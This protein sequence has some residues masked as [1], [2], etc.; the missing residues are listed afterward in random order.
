M[1][2][3]TP[4]LLASLLFLTAHSKEPTPSN[5]TP[6]PK[7]VTTAAN[8]TETVKER[9]SPKPTQQQPSVSSADNSLKSRNYSYGYWVNGFRKN[10][11]DDSPDQLA[12]ETGYY[13]LV[14]DLD[15]LPEARFGRVQGKDYAS[16]LTFEPQDTESLAPAEL[17]I[18][19]ASTDRVFTA[20]HSVTGPLNDA[21]RLQDTRLWESGRYLQNWEIQHLIFEDPDGN[22]LNCEAR[23]QVVGWPDSLTLTAEITPEL[24]F[25]DG[26]SAGVVGN[27]YCIAETPIALDRSSEQDFEAFTLEGWVNVPRNLEKSGK[28]WLISK[29]GGRDDDGQIGFYFDGRRIQ[30]AM[31]LG[32]G[33][34]NRHL[35]TESSSHP[36]N[37][38]SW[39]HLAL[40]Y[41]GANMHYYV[42]GKLQNSK[43]INQTR[44]PRKGPVR[45]GSAGDNDQQLA[46]GIF[47][48][49]R[50][51]DRPLS[52]DA[53]KAH[54]T[55]PE[56]I[57]DKN[58][59]RYEKTF[60]TRSDPQPTQYLWKNISTR[61]QLTTTEDTW[62]ARAPAIDQWDIG[63]TKSLTLNC[64][65]TPET[66][67]KDQTSVVVRTTDDQQITS[68]FNTELNCQVA[69][70]KKIER[71][72][73]T[74]YTDIRD[75][76]EFTLE[77]DNTSESAGEI[78]FMLYLRNVANITGLV[79][80]LCHEDGTPTG[81]PVQISKNW[82]YPKIGSYLRAYTQL[83]ALPGK[84]NYKLR[85]A[86]GFYGTLPSASH[87]QLSLV[88]YGG[89]NRWDQL[90]IGCWGETI[91]FDVDRSCVDVAV[92]DVRMLMARTGADGRKWSWTTAGWGGDW[93]YTQDSNGD[94]HH[95]S[96]LKTAYFAHGPCLTDVRYDGYYGSQ[97]EI[98]FD[99]QVQTLRTDDY[100]RT[101]QKFS[102]TFDKE[103]SAKDT[104]LFKMGRTSNYAHPQFAYGNADGLIA[105]IEAPATLKKNEFLL[106]NT[107]MTGTAPWWVSF[108]GAFQTRDDSKGTG[109]RAL[110]IRNYKATLGGKITTQ[111][112]FSI[113]VHQTNKDGSAN[114]DFL[115]T[116]PK[117]I[118]HFQPGDTIEMDLEW[119]T[120]HREADDYYGP[121]ETYRQHLTENP[122]SWKT[123][124]RE[125][126]G[127]DLAIDVTGGTLL[128][129]Y[130]IQIQAGTNADTVS[131]Q[132]E[133]GVG[134][135]PIRFQGLSSANGYTLYQRFGG[136]QIPLDQSVHG[137]D[138]WQTD[139][140]TATGSYS[141]VYNLPLDELAT[142]DWILKR[143]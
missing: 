54:Y 116:A 89:N 42:N 20:K 56:T 14:L 73:K 41:D 94:R 46:Y 132:I 92:T 82:H 48:Q 43:Q 23:L 51:W 119:I 88:G 13:G 78:P 6:E 127:N 37:F 118:E 5:S 141:R 84:Q 55:N 69:E 107:E 3:L 76:D 125:A 109:Y 121:N 66:A 93:L 115:L 15:N 16:G 68:V 24:P 47:D 133:G 19:I 86:Y 87:A 4:H 12:L 25:V 77:I 129:H 22:T 32:G 113:P 99:A 79:P 134:Y 34:R 21:R 131:V 81:I 71:D 63:Q 142:S 40:A 10:P 97:R 114:L 124:Y 83:P 53:I 95:P 31:N 7:P 50:I 143:Q 18:Q 70:I 117:G 67:P 85:I 39:Y 11:D 29:N 74:G 103:V 30:A 45:L 9:P 140:D 38:D 33:S 44:K 60:D 126:I 104:W 57:A 96:G 8:T 98:A 108:P 65:L 112:S 111:P 105:N 139:Y 26:P 75:Y 58:G 136:E 49:I 137:N 64:N 91:C 35:I 122:S 100:A 120:L 28:G 101:F 123:T 59:L 72:W 62:E 17:L 61:I 36:F 106:E 2:K 102:Y 80:I 52:K 138:F 130:P 128:N 90:A 110:V 135:V 1:H 27:G